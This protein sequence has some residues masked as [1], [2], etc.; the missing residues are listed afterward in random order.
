MNQTPTTKT[1]ADC[2]PVFSIAGVMPSGSNMAWT[3]SYPNPDAPFSIPRR[4]GH[5]PTFTLAG[6]V[7]GAATAPWRTAMP[8]PTR[9]AI[10]AYGHLTT[11]LEAA[12]HAE[13]THRTG[14]L[15]VAAGGGH[16]ATTHA[17]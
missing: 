15:T 7:Q 6:V 17:A 8:D 2:G 9:D 1:D 14:V 11:K 16:A 5:G 10:D 13:L 3:T 12:A 4:G